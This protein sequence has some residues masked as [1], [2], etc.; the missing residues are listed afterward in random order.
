MWGG[1]S[2]IIFSVHDFSVA[3]HSQPVYN[4]TSSQNNMFS[5]ARQTAL[6]RA[7]SS[8]PNA[9]V[10]QSFAQQSLLTR[11]ASSLAVLEQ[12]DGKLNSSSLAAV[13]AGAKVGGGITGILAGSNIK[14][15]A[16]EVAKV[17]GVEKVIYIENA[18]YDKGLP[19]HFAPL[20]VENIKKGGFTHVFAGHSA[21][22]KTLMPR[23]AALLDVQQISDI[24]SIESEDSM[25][26]MFCPVIHVHHKLT[27]SSVRPPHLRRQRNPHRPIFRSGQGHH[28]PQH[29]FPA[30]GYGLWQRNG[31]R[32]RGPQGRAHYRMGR[33]RAGQVRPAG[34]RYRGQGRF[35]WPWTQVQGGV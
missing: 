23:V 5:A 11:L 15:V 10:R 31:G 35:R 30:R 33:R 29:L 20:L 25:S 7:R 3:F 6:R 8:C 24:T 17:E 19:E 18:A 32:G 16:E 34:T 2:R 21:F 12:R 26:P 14:A 22:G 1:A 27:P 4:T 9:A 13:T 28:P